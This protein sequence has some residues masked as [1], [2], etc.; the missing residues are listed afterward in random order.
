MGLCGVWVSLLCYSLFC[1]GVGWAAH[2]SVWSLLLL[3]RIDD[4]SSQ[5]PVAPAQFSSRIRRPTALLDF[6][7]SVTE[8]ST[9]FISRVSVVLLLSRDPPP[10]ALPSTFLTRAQCRAPPPP[11]RRAQRF[12]DFSLAAEQKQ[13][14]SNYRIIEFRPCVDNRQ[15][16]S[17]RDVVWRR[18]FPQ[19]NVV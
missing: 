1:L 8:K 12:L 3:R 14:I 9:R 16:G 11:T 7:Q 13:K 5:L 19:G 10:G 15:P 2:A 6:Y 17:T 18:R 4:V